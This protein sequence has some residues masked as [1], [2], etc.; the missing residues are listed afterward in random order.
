[1]SA[2]SPIAPITG[3]RYA[4]GDCHGVA[5]TGRFASKRQFLLD[6]VEKVGHTKDKVALHGS[7][8]KRETNVA[9]LC[10]ELGITRQTL[11]RHP[12]PDGTLRDDGKKV[13]RQS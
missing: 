12:T 10:E 6:H 3:C 9:T 7:V 13:L 4:S 5:L 2:I 1:V 8:G 11:Y